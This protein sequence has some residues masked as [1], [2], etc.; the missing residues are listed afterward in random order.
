[1]LNVKLDKDKSYICK[2][3]LEAMKNIPCVTGLSAEQGG[4]RHLPIRQALS[5][6]NHLGSTPV[7]EASQNEHKDN[8]EGMW[9]T[10]TSDDETYQPEE[11]FMINDNRLT[12]VHL[13]ATN[14]N[15]ESKQFAHRHS[16][17][18]TIANFHYL[19]YQVSHRNSSH[20]S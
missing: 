16:F 20:G 10:I 9:R 3:L 8:L 6:K 18:L 5:T 11:F 12:C 14:R 2:Q 7:H 13:A 15:L 4:Q 17:S 19:S 1:V